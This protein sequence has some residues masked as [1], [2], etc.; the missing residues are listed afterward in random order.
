M[1]RDQHLHLVWSGQALVA[2]SLLTLEEAVQ[3]IRAAFLLPSKELK[4]VAHPR[5]QIQM[6][7]N[8]VFP[9]TMLLLRRLYKL[10]DPLSISWDHNP[11]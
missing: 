7:Q 5:H 2:S 9:H 11:T 10:R 8:Q 6:Y 1:Q 3:Q 4:C